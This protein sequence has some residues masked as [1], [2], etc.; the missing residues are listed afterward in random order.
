[1][2]ECFRI[3]EEWKIGNRPEVFHVVK[4]EPR[5]FQGGV[6]VASLSGDEAEPVKREVFM[7]WI[8]GRVA[9]EILGF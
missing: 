6:M 5:F 7:M 4:D 8:I 2:M 1:M 9:V 3:L